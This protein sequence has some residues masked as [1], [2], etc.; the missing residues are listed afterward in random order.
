MLRNWSE[1]PAE[2]AGITPADLAACRA[3]LSNGSRTFHAASL[4][5]PPAVRAPATALYAFCRVADDAIDADGGSPFA[6]AQLRDRL[7]RIYRGRPLPVPADRAFAAVV[8]QFGIPRELP[9]ALIEGFA[10]DAEGRSYASLDA[11]SAYAA[12]VAGTVGA[13]MSLIMG[14]RAPDVVARACD[15]G[16]AMQYTNIA[17]DV[18]EDA[19]MGRLY[20]PRDWLLEAGVDPE[21]WLGNPV[22]TPAIGEVVARLLAAAGELYRRAETGIASLPAGCR[23][24]MQAARFIYAAI[25]DEVARQ[26]FDSVSRRAYVGPS[27]KVALALVATFAALMPRSPSPA[28]ALPATQFLV[29]AATNAF[30]ASMRS[31]GEASSVIEH[32]VVW[33]LGLF[34][35][36]ERRHRADAG[37]NG[38]A[39][40]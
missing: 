26:H 15:L 9:D 10:W 24:G 16:V 6:V 35:R 23:P 40:A 25:G 5:L 33:L 34:E 7:D 13:M 11:L 30:P 39:A 20:L 19:R 3:L 1:A 4:F 8:R 32:R 21:A 17:R 29:S 18:G 37:W 22:F 28:P 2:S 12:R 36:L 38:P 27:R 14:A 31:A